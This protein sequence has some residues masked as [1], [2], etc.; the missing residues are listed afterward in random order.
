M[1]LYAYEAW[2]V[3]Q[4]R[5]KDDKCFRDVALKMG[6]ILQ[7]LSSRHQVISITH[8]PQIAV[9]ADTHYFVYKKIVEDRTVTNVKLLTFDER[10]RAVATMLS[11]S[12]PSDSA[13]AN[14]KELLKL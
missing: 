14:A 13:I 1:A 4:T 6:N 10:V 3:K 7:E 5:R 9:K 8:T 11:G 2:T 12:P